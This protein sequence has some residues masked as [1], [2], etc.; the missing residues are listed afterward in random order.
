MT[1]L[2][3]EAEDRGE[4]RMTQKERGSRQRYCVGGVMNSWQRETLH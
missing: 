2:G 4:A 3:E 1:K